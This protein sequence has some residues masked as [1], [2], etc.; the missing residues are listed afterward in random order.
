MGDHKLIRRYD[1]ESLELYNLKQDIGEKQNLATQ[2]PELSER[3]N[4]KLSAWLKETDARIPV[5]GAV[6][7]PKRKRP[8]QRK[9]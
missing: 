4:D 8:A 2:L 6:G 7:Q 1:D 9:K 3:L 5:H